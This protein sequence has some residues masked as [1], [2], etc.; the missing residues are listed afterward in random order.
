MATQGRALA[1][2]ATLADQGVLRTTLTETMTGMTAETILAA[3]EKVAA[4][5]VNGKLAIEF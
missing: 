3:Q 4:G 2:A 1:L 5:K